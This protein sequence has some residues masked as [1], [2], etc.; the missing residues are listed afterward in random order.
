MKNTGFLF[1]PPTHLISY[2]LS[3]SQVHFFFPLLFCFFS[4]SVPTFPL[5][6]W[7][8]VQP[9]AT[10]AVEFQTG[11]CCTYWRMLNFCT[12]IAFPKWSPK[13]KRDFI[14]AGVLVSLYYCFFFSW[15]KRILCSV[16]YTLYCG[17]IGSPQITMLE[18]AAG[19]KS[20]SVFVWRNFINEKVPWKCKAWIHCSL[21]ILQTCQRS[22]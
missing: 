13:W 16:Q 6:P 11:F 14:T 19:I 9:T 10:Q 20:Y 21:L 7:G 2:L 18:I 12:Q 22:Q 4:P 1:N 8:K 3:K 15:C 17:F 5:S